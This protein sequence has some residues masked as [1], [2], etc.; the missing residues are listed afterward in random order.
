[1][2]NIFL[3]TKT[4]TSKFNLTQILKYSVFAY[5]T[6][7]ILQFYPTYIIL[8]DYVMC[9]NRYYGTRFR[10]FAF[11]RH[12]CG[13]K[14]NPTMYLLMSCGIYTC[15]YCSIDF[16]K[17]YIYVTRKL[18]LNEINHVQMYLIFITQVLYY[19]K[20]RCISNLK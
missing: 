15:H 17:E 12:V 6:L 18:I 10:Y 19:N 3:Y 8:V 7:T 9:E 2:Y 4:T 16:N 1:M 13:F 14:I 20:L 11:V 5:F